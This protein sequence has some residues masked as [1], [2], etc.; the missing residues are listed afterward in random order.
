MERWN[1]L[2]KLVTL[3]SVEFFIA[4]GAS[5]MAFIVVQSQ[6]NYLWQQLI[7]QIKN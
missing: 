1:S 4:F 3:P 6:W 7:V 2:I 5:L